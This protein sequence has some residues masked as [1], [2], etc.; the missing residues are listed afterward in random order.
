MVEKKTEGKTAPWKS[1]MKR[2]EQMREWQLSVMK[3]RRYIIK[4]KEGCDWFWKALRRWVGR[5]NVRLVC[6][7]G[8]KNFGPK[9]MLHC[10]H[11]TPFR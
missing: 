2:K 8:D 5:W 1:V 9:T 6:Y 11:T 3:G 10:K 4:S 7:C